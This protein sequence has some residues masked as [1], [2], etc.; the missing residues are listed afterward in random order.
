[1]VG[2]A[3]VDLVEELKGTMSIQTI[4]AH[5]GVARAPYTVDENN[6]EYCPIKIVEIKRFV[7]LVQPINIVM[8]IVVSLL[9]FQKSQKKRYKE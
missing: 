5:M 6:V 1:M 9:Y 4:C 2:Q 7:K 3:F 8:A